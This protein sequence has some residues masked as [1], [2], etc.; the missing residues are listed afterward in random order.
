MSKIYIKDW[1]FF[2]PYD[3]QAPTD[4]FYMKVGNDV[5]HQLIHNEHASELQNYLDDDDLKRLACFLTSYFEDLISGSNLWNSFIKVH[6][7]LY[8][9]QLPF[10]KLD[11][12]FEEEINPQDVAFLIWYYINT[13]QTE[14]FVIPQHEMILEAAVIVYDVFDGAWDDAP[15]NDRLLSFYTIDENVTDFYQARKLI[16]DI[17]FNSYLFLTDT[18]SDFFERSEDI[19]DRMEDDPNVIAYLNDLQDGMIHRSRTRLFAF[20]GKEWVAEIIGKEHKL[21][22]DFLAMF[23][24]FKATFY[25]KDKTTRRFSSNI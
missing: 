17:L 3:K 14:L 23:E 16:D 5:M 25:I 12:Y 6:T 9:K 1:L 11:D 2:K 8:N 22:P 20:S 13:S 4:G 10:Y 21:Y 24:K 18:F 19:L 7:R 15:E